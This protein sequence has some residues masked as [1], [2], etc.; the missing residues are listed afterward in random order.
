MASKERFLFIERDGAV[1]DVV[2]L[3][4][5][6]D[7]TDIPSGWLQREEGDSTWHRKIKQFPEPPYTRPLDGVTA[8]LGAKAEAVAWIENRPDPEYLDLDGKVVKK[9]SRVAV[10]FALGRGA[11]IRIGVVTGFD[12]QFGGYGSSP[13][14]DKIDEREQIVVEWEKD[15]RQWG[16]GPDK[17]KIFAYL[18]RYIVIG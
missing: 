11:E 10:A 14:D 16:S 6:E 5:Y 7:E 8:R 3:D 4:P 17:S 13:R 1:V 12:R 15:N 18:R 2:K 9:G